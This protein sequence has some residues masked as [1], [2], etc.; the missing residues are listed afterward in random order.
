MS[1]PFYGT[2]LGMVET[3]GLV[4]AIE[5]ADAM[6]KAADVRILGMERA[7]AGLVTVQITGE[8]AA[9]QASVD[10]GAAAAA[11][12][13]QLVARHVIARP[14]ADTVRILGDDAT[15]RQSVALEDMTVRELR[16][17]ARTVDG[18]PIQGRAIA[19]ATKDQLLEAF[20]SIG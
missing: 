16:A 9:V 3:R 7:D 1:P 6:V 2:A 12:V 20:R 4:G 13:G 14:D 8:V 19:S 11:R 10:A 15:T 17:H 18:F 5:A